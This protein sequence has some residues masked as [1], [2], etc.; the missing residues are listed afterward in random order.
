MDRF[1]IICYN[2]YAKIVLFRLGFGDYVLQLIKTGVI[3]VKKVYWAIVDQVPEEG[4]SIS[5]TKINISSC[6]EG[7]FTTQ[8]RVTTTLI[9]KIERIADNMCIL[10]TEECGYAVYYTE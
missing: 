4:K 6:V 7:I 5:L 1:Y 8:E 3:L 9:E 2:R 10:W